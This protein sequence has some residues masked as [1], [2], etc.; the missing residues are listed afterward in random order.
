MIFLL[1]ENDMLKLIS[2]AVA[3][4]LALALVVSGL[5]HLVG[6][7]E[8]VAAPAPMP[9]AGICGDATAAAVLPQCRR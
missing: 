4:L 9:M 2:G 5:A 1:K 3:A 6:G 8:A 7:V